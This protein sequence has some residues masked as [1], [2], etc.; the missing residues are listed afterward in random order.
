VAVGL[1]G[2]VVADH[3]RPRIGDVVAA[4]TGDRAVIDSR[5]LPASILALV[6]LHGGVTADELDVPLLVLRT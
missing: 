6:G 4:A 3:V 1:Y 2:P 5:L